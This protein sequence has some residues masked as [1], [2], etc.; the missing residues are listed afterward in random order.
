MDQRWDEGVGAS[1]GQRGSTARARRS[2]ATASHARV[3]SLPWGRGMKLRMTEVGRGRR[4]GTVRRR[5]SL[6]STAAGKT[7][8][9]GLLEKYSR[10]Q[11][12]LW[13]GDSIPMSDPPLP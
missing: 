12:L 3:L 11:H 9:G 2:L 13:L 4:S 8:Y 7:R 5:Q 1:G 10:T 6:G